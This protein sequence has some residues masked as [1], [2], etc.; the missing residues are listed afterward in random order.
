MKKQGSALLF[1]QINLN[2][3][4]NVL[5]LVSQVAAVCDSKTNY[6]AVEK[7]GT[8]LKKRKWLLVESK[9]F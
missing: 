8:F 7:N 4:S 6:T 9:A 3:D 5:F 1:P 2:Y